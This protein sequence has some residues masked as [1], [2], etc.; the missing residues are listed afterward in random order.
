MRIFVLK[1]DSII[2]DLRFEPRT[3][4]VGSGADCAIRLQDG[5]IA[6]SHFRLT[7]TDAGGWNLVLVEHGFPTQLNGVRIR[8]DMELKDLD[9]I[10]LG[11]YALKMYLH[12][13]RPAA[14]KKKAAA[15]SDRAAGFRPPAGS[16][17][18]RYKDD[19]VLTQ[20]HVH[21]YTDQALD[22]A[23]ASNTSMLIELVLQRLTAAF[24]A[25]IACMRVRQKTASGLEIVQ[26]C[27]AKG[28]PVD[29]P[30]LSAKLEELCGQNLESVCLPPGATT[31][32]TPVMAVP[33]VGSRDAALG[34]IYVEAG[35][36]AVFDA[37]ALNLL[38]A[39]AAAVAPPLE[40]T[41]HEAAV[42]RAKDAGR[43]QLLARKVQDALTLAAMPNWPDVQMAAYRRPGVSV[44]CDHYDMLRLANRTI[45]YLIVR[46]D[47][48]GPMLPRLMAEVH[49][50]FR[51]CCLHAE[52]PHVIAR[53][54]NWLIGTSHSGGC[55][56]VGCVWLA[57]ETGLLR[58]CVAGPGV[59]VG[60]ITGSG[61]WRSLQ[62]EAAPAIGRQ[63]GF[64]YSDQ[65]EQLAPGDMVALLT[66]GADVF[67]NPAG[68][69]FG[70]ERI[71]EILCDL[72]G[73]ATTVMLSD[74]VSELDEFC[75]ECASRDDLTV[76]LARWEGAAG[77][78]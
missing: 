48:A 19:L 12:A 70:R 68:E 78:S 73:T 1:N 15:R 20:K 33:I 42:T 22:L 67:L 39:F 43:E 60:I 62:A 28:R 40:R 13:G 27:D 10:R 7:P 65:T 56:N 50:S 8:R 54:L 74:L 75:G 38:S 47:G 45:A 25:A 57:P 2:D 32:A 58:S 37:H 69:I 6:E 9:E 3:L 16:L 34:M 55:V 59:S 63:R 17:R 30:A 41:I 52:A 71:I 29:V 76:I 21:D 53:T 23:S 49:A 26:A 35:E 64:A 66:G 11:P 5:Q 31:T 18:R 72:A 46:A 36:G 24:D 44:V 61:E 4:Q 14:G 51:T 77:G